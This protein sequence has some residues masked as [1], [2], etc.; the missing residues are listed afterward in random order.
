MDSDLLKRRTTHFT[1]WAPQQTSPE[2]VIGT[3]QFGTPPSHLARQKP[4]LSAV[5]GVSDLWEI[6]AADCRLVD[7]TVYHYWFEVNDTRPGSDPHSRVLVTDPL[8]FAPDW[9]LQETNARFLV[10]LVL[11]ESTWSPLVFGS[12]QSRSQEQNGAAAGNLER[13]GRFGQ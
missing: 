7:A 9:R 4:G 2:L 8:T 11:E 12:G 10:G 6:A 3:F 5:A 13:S 1:L